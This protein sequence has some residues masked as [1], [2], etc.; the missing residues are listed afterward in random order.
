MSRKRCW[1]HYY[2]RPGTEILGDIISLMQ[3]P[4]SVAKPN[5]TR[6]DYLRTARWWR[7][8][9]LRGYPSSRRSLLY[10]RTQEWLSELAA[11]FGDGTP[12]ELLRRS[13]HN[14]PNFDEWMKDSEVKA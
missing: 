8:E 14:M 1:T 13:G 4:F 5:V 2:E 11:E 3:R 6:A 9:S 7:L 10:A 12:A